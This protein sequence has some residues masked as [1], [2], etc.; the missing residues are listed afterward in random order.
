MCAEVRPASEWNAEVQN[1]STHPLALRPAILR[2]AV[3]NVK[4]WFDVGLEGQPASRVDPDSYMTESCGGGEAVGVLEAGAVGNLTATLHGEIAPQLVETTD[5]GAHY[6]WLFRPVFD[7]P[8]S[9]VVTAVLR[10]G[11]SEFRSNA[12]TLQ[13]LAPPEA[14]TPALAELK[15]L[16]ASGICPDVQAMLRENTMSELEL[17]DAYA[18]HNTGTVCGAQT[19][20]CLAVA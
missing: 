7:Q 4:L 13:V 15:A 5:S 12:V 1:L 8:G 17:L 2:G 20:L 3:T 18:E 14:W 19:S 10:W 9:Y 11:K 6:E 16:A